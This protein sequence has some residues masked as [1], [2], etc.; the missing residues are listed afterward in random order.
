MTLNPKPLI[1]AR[2]NYSTAIRVLLNETGLQHY[3][4]NAGIE[5]HLQ[6]LYLYG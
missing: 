5:N 1:S 4:R 3:S 2:A 6:A